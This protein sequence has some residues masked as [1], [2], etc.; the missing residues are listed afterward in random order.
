M[1]LSARV[2]V[3][4]M[5]PFDGAS[6]RSVSPRGCTAFAPRVAVP[7]NR[8]LRGTGRGSFEGRAAFRDSTP[9]RWSWTYVTAARSKKLQRDRNIKCGKLRPRSLYKPEELTS[10]VHP[11]HHDKTQ[12]PY[13]HSAGTPISPRAVQ[14]S[15][16]PRP[17][18]ISSQAPRETH[19]PSTSTHAQP[20]H[21]PRHGRPS[22]QPQTPHWADCRR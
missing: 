11:T 2:I 14:T 5:I 9:P 20:F 17:R 19:L 16:T 13:R 6:R 22:T 4:A 7:R 18:H 10:L 1:G 21:R 8:R 3:S 12:R 15:K